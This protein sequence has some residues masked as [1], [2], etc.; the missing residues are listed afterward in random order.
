MVDDHL[1]F[2]IE[3]HARERWWHEDHLINQRTTWLLSTQS[4]LAG[5]FGFLRYRIAEISNGELTKIVLQNKAV[6]LETLSTLSLGL[7]LIG[8]VSSLVSLAGIHAAVVA[9][10]TL[11]AQYGMTPGVAPKTTLT[12]QLVAR[13]TPTLCALAWLMAFFAFEIYAAVIKFA[14]Q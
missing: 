6:Y 10:R 5:G 1:N 14:C 9:Q 8:F 11:A 7:L 2:Q 3:K 12:G 4:I 13:A